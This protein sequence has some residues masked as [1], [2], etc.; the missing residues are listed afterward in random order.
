[1]LKKFWYNT[2][3][4][5]LKGRKKIFK[6]VLPMAQ[7]CSAVKKQEKEVHCSI[8]FMSLMN[9]QLELAATR[10]KLFNMVDSFQF[11]EKLSGLEA[12][13]ISK[14]KLCLKVGM[15]DT[16]SEAK[17]KPSVFGKIYRDFTK[18]QNL[19]IIPQYTSVEEILNVIFKK[20]LTNRFENYP[21]VCSSI[22]IFV[23][24]YFYYTEA[25]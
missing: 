17:G 24:D 12:S 7:I 15:M 8:G 2:N 21:L 10:N 5:F 25:G 9:F 13:Y 1:M 23:G 20:N 14:F 22:A 4:L 3:C 19:L 16:L 18:M 11:G 6:G